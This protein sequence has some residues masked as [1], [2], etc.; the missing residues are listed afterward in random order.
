[1][2]AQLSIAG[3]VCTVH[4][5][6]CLMEAFC[7]LAHVCRRSILTDEPKLSGSCWDDISDN[8]KDFLRNILD[9]WGTQS[10]EETGSTALHNEH[11]GSA[12]AVAAAAAAA[13]AAVAVP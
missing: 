9:K 6:L 3:S 5:V 4:V 7:L 8:A 10:R 13:A 2:L 1:M 11:K 12:A